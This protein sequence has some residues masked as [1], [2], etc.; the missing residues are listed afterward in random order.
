VFV[1]FKRRYILRAGTVIV[2]LLQLRIVV[3]V[4][5]TATMVATA[6]AVAIATP[7]VPGTIISTEVDRHTTTLGKWRKWRRGG[8]RGRGSYLLDLGNNSHGLLF[9][10][11]VV[12]C[13]CIWACLCLLCEK[14]YGILQGH[15]SAAFQNINPAQTKISLRL[16]TD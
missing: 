5:V 10:R 3:V 1:A 16:L 13:F 4:I 6:T 8:C 7:H 2:L 15:Y 11:S 12:G 9:Q 14:K